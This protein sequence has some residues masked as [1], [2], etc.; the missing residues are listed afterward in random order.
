MTA[1]RTILMSIARVTTMQTIPIL[2]VMVTRVMAITITRSMVF[3]TAAGGTTAIIFLTK[4]DTEKRTTV[5]VRECYMEKRPG[6][7]RYAT[8]GIIRLWEA[9]H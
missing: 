5:P 7:I 2:T 8:R 4:H 3:V 6:L 9:G 1:I